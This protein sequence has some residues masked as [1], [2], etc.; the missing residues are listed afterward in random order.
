[1]SKFT[2]STLTAIF[3]AAV[4]LSVP[5]AAR[6]AENVHLMLDWIPTGDY[7]PYY[8]G[9]ASGIYQRNG[10]EL[11][12]SKGNGSGDTLSKVAGG[13]ADIGMA[14]ISALFT[15]RQ[16]SSVPLKMIGAVYAHSPHSLFVRKDSGITT[17]TGLEGKKIGITP[18]NSHRLYFP[19][20][21]A[22]AKTD[23]N[24]IEWV[25]VDG[26]AMGPL[27][28][29]GKV[30]AIPSYSTNFYYQ[31]KQAQRAGKELAFLPFVEAGFAIYSL[32][33]HTTEASAK[34][35]P[36]MLKSFMKATTESWEAARDN[37]QATC[38]AHV[39]AIPQ[40]D[41]D[42]CLGSLKATLGFIFTDHAKEAGVG[43]ITTERLNK[44]Y[45]VVAQSQNL[46]PKLDPATA[47]DMSF[48]PPK[49]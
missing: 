29:S 19:A 25:T 13:A 4:A 17:F 49:K 14:D 12:I 38:E 2:S 1:M 34:N 27:L 30:D 43:G 42:D 6:A 20:V 7:A 47:V 24:K 8:A 15:A 39:K 35:R 10:I 11:R 9:I 45:E 22:A 36:E 41:L 3:S 44:T 32:A 18:G 40:V 23:P 5:S 46:D 28:I 31:N 21:A 16:R 48:L 26:S 37:P 33:F